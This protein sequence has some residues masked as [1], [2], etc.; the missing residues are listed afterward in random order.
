MS[1]TRQHFRL[2]RP[3]RGYRGEE[4]WRQAT[5]AEVDCRH[6]LQGWQTTV[7]ATSIQADYIRHRCERVFSEA[8]E[9]L[10]AVFT[11]PAGQRCF[12]QHKIPLERDPLCMFQSGAGP[13]RQQ[14]VSQWIDNFAE[15]MH[16]LQ[17]SITG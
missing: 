6:Y 12:R 8:R 9:G 3:L 1:N 13:E 14:E 16:R 7:P 4:F 2:A 15:R 17:R 11:F 10:D 5:C